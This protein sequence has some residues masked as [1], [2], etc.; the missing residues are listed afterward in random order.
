MS[1]RP[2]FPRLIALPTALVG[3]VPG[4][5]SEMGCKSETCAADA[6]ISS[7]LRV[8][9]RQHP[10]LEA[11]NSVRVQTADGVGYLHGHVDTE[12]QRDEAAALARQ[13]PGVR[14]VV[15]S[16]RLTYAGG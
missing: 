6:R 13:V 10:A 3:S 7:Q 8:S 14:D 15:D 5:A 2:A 16:L 1:I 9:I 4:C 12:L 11:P